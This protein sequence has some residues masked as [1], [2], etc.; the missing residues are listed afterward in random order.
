MENNKDY[1]AVQD[2]EFAQEISPDEWET[3]E[4]QID[5]E[6]EAIAQAQEWANKHHCRCAINTSIRYEL[7][8]CVEDRGLVE[9]DPPPIIINP[10]KQEG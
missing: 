1:K 5:T 10:K 3:V 4:I 9:G 6:P 8:G 2:W 7:N